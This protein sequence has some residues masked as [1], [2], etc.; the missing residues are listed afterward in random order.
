MYTLRT[1]EKRLDNIKQFQNYRF[2]FQYLSKKNTRSDILYF[3]KTI[4]SDYCT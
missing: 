4:F 2:F 3:C 1:M